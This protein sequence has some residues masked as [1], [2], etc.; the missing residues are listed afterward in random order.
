VRTGN[1]FYGYRS[2]DGANWT[3]VNFRNIHMAT[4]IY[5][6]LAVAS[7]S[8]NT[9]TTASFSNITVVP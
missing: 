8:S 4:S 5:V 6:G 1:T 9:V 3:Q 2:A 7:G